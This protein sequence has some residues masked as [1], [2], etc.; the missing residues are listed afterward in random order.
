[1]DHIIY[2]K[3]NKEALIEERKNTEK[4]SHA[5]FLSEWFLK[6]KYFWHVVLSKYCLI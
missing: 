6:Y 1:M 2:I 5:S 4:E 3:T